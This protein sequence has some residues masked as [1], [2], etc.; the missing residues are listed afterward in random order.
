MKQK[1]LILDVFI[2]GIVGALSAQAFMFLLRICQSFF[3]SGLAGYHP[4]GLPE[5]GGVLLQVI[6]PHGLWLIPLAT[7][8]G[9]LISG[10]LVYSLAPEAEGHGTDSAVKAFHRAGGYIRGRIPGLK[11]LTSAITIGSGGAAGRE[12]PTAL[13]SAGIGSIYAGFGHRSDE[14]RRILVLTGMAAG[15]SAI[16]RSPIGAALFVIE[17]L[18]SDMEFEASAL[19]Y[20]ILASVTAY[21]LNGVM[22]GWE[23]LFRFPAGFGFPGLADYGWY[24]IL[25]LISGLVAA[26]LPVLF[27]GLRDGFRRLPILDHFKPAI[28]GLGVGLLAMGLPQVL[29]GGYGWIQEAMDGSLT[30]SL[31]LL[32]VFG[33]M[34]AFCLTISSGGSGGVFAPGLYIGA[35]VGGLLA[36]QFQLPPAGFVVVGMVAVFGGV[37]RVPIASLI[38]VTEM[39]GGYHLLAAAALSVSLS[40]VVQVS[41]T[42]RLK[43]K[44]NSLYEAQVPRRSDSP[45]HHAELLQIA[46]NLMNQQ[47]IAIP[48]VNGHL[49]LLKLLSSGIPVDLPECKQLVIVTMNPQSPWIGRSVKAGEFAEEE[50]DAEIIAILRQEHMRLPSSDTILQSGDQLLLIV[51]SPAWKRLSQILAPEPSHK[52]EG[53]H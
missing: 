46:L 22:V 44:Y 43:F 21:V 28:G 2:L 36:Q 4:P 42:S 45:A 35:M 37:A 53:I 33:K 49:N 47:R 29:G 8:L 50:Q 31:L 20:T 52:N 32:L 40:Y 39:T 27:Y 30:T 16:F 14:E 24:I 18:Y 13:I 25:G 48:S 6:G 11:M 3:L 23:P 5:E 41:L 17:V 26:V 7:T 1:R 38:M 51:S 15:L 19:L 9:G 34:I 12:G 10:V